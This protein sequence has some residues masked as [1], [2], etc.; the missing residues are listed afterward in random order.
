[1]NSIKEIYVIRP[2]KII[3]VDRSKT[4]IVIENY[5]NTCGLPE[6]L[7]VPSGVYIEPES[8]LVSG[9]YASDMKFSGMDCK[10]R[11]ILVGVETAQ[12]LKAQKFKGAS[13]V[14]IY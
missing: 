10:S 4:E 2:R 7:Y 14:E 6:G 5:C 1:M 9:I 3:R 11:M 13:F 8:P 12:L